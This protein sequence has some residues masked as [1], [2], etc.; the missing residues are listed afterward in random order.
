MSIIKQSNS[1]SMHLLHYLMDGYEA[2]LR[3]VREWEKAITV[4]IDI[5]IYGILDVVST[6]LFHIM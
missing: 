2:R 6:H 5:D 1:T 4:H 3:P